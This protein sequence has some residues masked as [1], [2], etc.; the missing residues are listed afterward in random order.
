MNVIYTE[1]LPDGITMKFYD[2]TIFIGINN[3]ND[4]QESNTYEKLDEIN[5]EDQQLK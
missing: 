1:L 4:F 3:R 2:G 5:N